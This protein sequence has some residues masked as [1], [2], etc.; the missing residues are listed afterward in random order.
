MLISIQGV[1][2]DSCVH[3]IV[4]EIIVLQIN[5]WICV[6]Q[7]ACSDKGHSSVVFAPNNACNVV[8]IRGQSMVP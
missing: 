3:E 8:H 6:S 1:G 2:E 4:S 5:L 7:C